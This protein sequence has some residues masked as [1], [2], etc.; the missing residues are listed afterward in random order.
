[1][2]SPILKHTQID[3]AARPA[4]P[5]GPAA[6]QRGHARKECRLIELDGV[7][8]AIEI[9]CACGETT[10]VELVLESSPKPEGAPIP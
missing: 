4:G 6:P 7:P 10:V 1:M 5:R 2:P 8:R 3:L 9:T